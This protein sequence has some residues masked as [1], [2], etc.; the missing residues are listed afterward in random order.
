MCDY[1]PSELAWLDANGDTTLGSTQPADG[2]MNEP[3][4]SP[5]DIAEE[6]QGTCEIDLGF[7]WCEAK[8][9]CVQNW[10]GGVNGP[11]E[12]IKTA[13]VQ[14]AMNGFISTDASVK[15]S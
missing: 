9:M 11:C 12:P 4:A 10:G 14:H 8:H 7:T 6:A 13:H 2:V 5:Q 1:T 3:D 15:R